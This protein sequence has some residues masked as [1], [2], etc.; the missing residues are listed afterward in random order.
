MAEFMK[1]LSPAE[2]SAHIIDNECVAF[3]LF[4][5]EIGKY[6]LR[7]PYCFVEGYDMPYYAPRV[8][9][10]SDTRGIFINCGGKKGVIAA[11]E[12]IAAKPA[13][14]TYKTLYFVDKDYDDNSSLS[15]RIFVTD[16]YSVENYYASDTA[17]RTAFSGICSINKD[18]EQELNAVMDLY[19]DWKAKFF[20][21]THLFCGWYAN[22]KNRPDR[23][24]KKD[25]DRQVKNTKYKATFPQK[26][27]TI[28]SKGITKLN[29]SLE[30]LNSDY[31]INSP[32][33]SLELDSALSSITSIDDIRGKYVIQLVQEF[34]EAIRLAATAK[35][36]PISK[37]FSFEKN[38]NTILARLS[39][40]ADTSPRLR[41]YLITNLR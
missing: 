7:H 15:E 16:G 37:D 33:T 40:A 5:E 30:D 29:Y 19:Q 39:F 26:Y 31:E 20:D 3:K 11:Y 21:A 8:N 9:T 34:I 35:K 14:S 6:G 23:K 22:T 28:S 41:N 25:K 10:F 1:S 38:N 13:Y 32:V 24:I 27:A 12:F 2:M 18:R 36:T 17:I 4:V